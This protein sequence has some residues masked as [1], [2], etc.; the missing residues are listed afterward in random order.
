MLK[1]KNMQ[2]LH[3]KMAFGTDRTLTTSL[4]WALGLS[5]LIQLL[6]VLPY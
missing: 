6:E 1:K 2:V 4:C 3:F 5:H